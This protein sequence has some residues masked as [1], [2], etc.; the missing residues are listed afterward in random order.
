MNKI[1]FSN[2]E[3]HMP[4]MDRLGR[5]GKVIDCKDIENILVSFGKGKTE[6]FCLE[7]G[8]K[9]YDELYYIGRESKKLNINDY[10]NINYKKLVGQTINM[11]VGR[12]KGDVY[13]TSWSIKNGQEHLT[14]RQKGNKCDK[15]VI[16]VILLK[17]KL[18]EQNIKLSH[19]KDSNIIIT[20]I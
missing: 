13:F 9:Y 7:K 20:Q 4:V 12:I 8:N 5:F 6:Y 15:L 2:L 10:K 1:L 3:Y 16:P 18:L 11:Q 17:H 19:R 14:F